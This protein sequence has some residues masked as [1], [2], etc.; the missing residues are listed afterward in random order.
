MRQHLYLLR[1]EMTV[2][3]YPDS[4]RQSWVY[5]P[6]S[7]GSEPTTVSSAKSFLKRVFKM[8]SLKFKE[9]SHSFLTAIGL[10]VFTDL[11]EKF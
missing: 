11:I 9:H 7:L 6:D 10:C 2:P 4:K 8:M 1:G 5:S 3:S